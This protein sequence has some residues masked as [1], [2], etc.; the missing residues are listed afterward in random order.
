MVLIAS[1]S[2][3]IS[4]R[5]LNQVLVGASVAAFLVVLLLGP[6]AEQSPDQERRLVMEGFF[7]ELAE[8]QAASPYPPLVLRNVDWFPR[9]PYAQ[10]AL[11]DGPFLLEPPMEGVQA[12]QPP[13]FPSKP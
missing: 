9:S 13:S 3:A 6:S 5:P 1:A 7:K 2:A 11:L 4:D 12:P 8:Y 10:C